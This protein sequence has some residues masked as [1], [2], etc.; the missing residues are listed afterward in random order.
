MFA[1]SADSSVSR[2]R[3]RTCTFCSICIGDRSRALCCAET[4]C[5][6]SWPPEKIGCTAIAGILR[7]SP[8]FV[9]NWL[10]RALVVLLLIVVLV[11]ALATAIAPEFLAGQL[12]M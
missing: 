2:C 3:L 8:M 7:E 12:Q 4:L 6:G 10:N 1:R 5:T 9:L 11:S